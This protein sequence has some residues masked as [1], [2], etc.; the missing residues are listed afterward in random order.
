M[1]IMVG[2]S[3]TYWRISFLF[4]RLFNVY[5]YI[6]IYY[7][8][9]DVNAYNTNTNTFTAQFRYQQNLSQWHLCFNRYTIIFTSWLTRGYVLTAFRTLLSKLVNIIEKQAKFK[10][11]LPLFLFLFDA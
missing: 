6:T 3:E 2:D 10:L 11:I 8:Y 5:N 7:I 4:I 9:I 1:I